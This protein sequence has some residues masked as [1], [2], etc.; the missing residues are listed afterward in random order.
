MPYYNISALTK[1]YKK[2]S[3]QMKKA[4]TELKEKGY[5][6]SRTHFDN[7]GLKTNAPYKEIIN[8]LFKK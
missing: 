7:H 8:T 2:E 6:A 4:I 5:K 3:K 1:I